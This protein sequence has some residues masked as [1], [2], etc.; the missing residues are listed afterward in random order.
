MK[1]KIIIA[2]DNKEWCNIL[3]KYLVRYNEFE[4][5]GIAN[6]DEDEIKLIEEKKTDIVITDLMRNGEYTGFD[7]IKEYSTHKNSPQFLI[8]SAGMPVST[9]MKCK[10]VANFIEKLRAE[11][12]DIIIALRNI[13]KDESYLIE[14]TIDEKCEIKET[15]TLWNKIK[16]FFGCKI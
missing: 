1:K 9:I 8:I 16:E 2:D 15:A 6:T 12:S 7:I 13:E 3:Y 14:D 4:I 11:P 5:L 10:N